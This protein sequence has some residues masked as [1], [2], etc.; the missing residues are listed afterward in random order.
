MGQ[1]AKIKWVI[2]G[3]ENTSFFHGT[4]KKK[5]RQVAIKGI[6]KNGDWI[7]NPVMVKA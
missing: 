4:L 5:R 1:K 7:E 6:L 3:D 2:E